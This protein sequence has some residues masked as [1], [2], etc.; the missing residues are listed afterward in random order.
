[1]NNSTQYLEYKDERNEKQESKGNKC[2]HGSSVTP[3]LG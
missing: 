1:M 3:M 2:R